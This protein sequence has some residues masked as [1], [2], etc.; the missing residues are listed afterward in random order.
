ML[1]TMS[2]GAGPECRIL[3]VETCARSPKLP[4]DLKH[5]PWYLY[6]SEA[7]TLAPRPQ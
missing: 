1:R 7:A 5:I 2:Y 6:S 3:A 4:A